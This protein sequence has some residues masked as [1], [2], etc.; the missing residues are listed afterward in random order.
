MIDRARSCAVAVC[1]VLV[2]AC[3]DESVA[4]TSGAT[5]STGATATSSTGAEPTTGITGTAG[6]ATTG[7]ATGTTG[8]SSGTGAPTTTGGPIDPSAA[9]EG[10]D[11][12]TT[13]GDTC[14]CV[15]DNERILVL[16]DD[17]EIWAYEPATD[18]FELL[19]GVVCPGLQTPYSMAVDR[20][21][22]AWILYADDGEVYRF[23]PGDP[24]PCSLAGVSAKAAGF[25]LFG[26]S[27]SPEDA[28]GCDRLFLF[29]Y[30]GEGPF[31]EAPDIGA[32]GVFDP[33]T[34]QVTHLGPTDYD[35]GEL[36]GTGDGRL[37]AFAGVGPAKLIEYDKSDATPLSVLPL[38]GL[39][40]TRAS[41]FAFHGGDAYFFTEA[42]EATCFPCLQ[43]SCPAVFDACG[44][45]PVCSEALGC[46]IALGEIQDEC[47]GY[48]TQAMIDCATTSCLAACYPDVGDVTSKVTRLDYDGSEGQGQAL[49]LVNSQA[50]IR[51]VGAAASTCAPYLPQ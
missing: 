27:F 9:S 49:T 7:E 23:D 11:T 19:A 28:G 12:A 6:S 1:V 42:V 8:T 44:A 21:G 30:S 25:S 33:A 37:F 18:T 32:L 35:G 47:G 36:A 39:R 48:M 5:G 51:I 13:G 50:P 4:S 29:D 38:D 20:Q 17:G 43:A 22:V 24:G 41:A 10:T 15:P 14:A 16:S 26:L 2:A 40:K 3:G 46:S 45:D 31:A 34:E